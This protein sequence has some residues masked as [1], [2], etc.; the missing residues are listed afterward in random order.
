V[1]THETLGSRLLQIVR[2]QQDT[3]REVLREHFVR[4]LEALS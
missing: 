3:Y 4:H 1:L 2:E